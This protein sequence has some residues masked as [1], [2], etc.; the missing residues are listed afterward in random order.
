M[1]RPGSIRRVSW[2]MCLAAA[3][4]GLAASTVARADD[5]TDKVNAPFKAIAEKSRSDLIILP[6]LAAMDPAPAVLRTQER[7][8]LLGSKG[9][10]WQECADW[11]QKPAQ[12]AVLEAIAQVTKE[13]DRL[14]AFA[15][16]QPYGVEGVSIDL[17][18]K[19][20]YTELGDPPLLSDARHLYMPAMENA[21]ILSHVEASRL[22]ASGDLAG[23]MKVMVDWMFFARQIA[24]RPMIKEKKWAMQSMI[25]ASERLRDLVYQDLVGDKPNID[26]A[27]LR[28][29]NDRLKE[30]RGFL[31]LDRIQFPEGDFVA[32]EQLV[33]QVFVTNAGP[34]E[35]TFPGT[36]ARITATDR[37]LT[38]FAG[39][40]FWGSAMKG[41]ANYR[42]TTSMLSGIGDDWR[43]RWQLDP[44]DKYVNTATDYRKRVQTTG[45][46]AVLNR[47]F[48]DVDS[49]FQLRRVLQTEVAGTR[50]AIGVYAFHVRFKSFPVSLAPVRP[51][52]IDTI[53]KDP[54]SSKKFDIRYL[55]PVRDTVKG[56]NGEE[57]LHAINLYP[58]APYPTFKVELGADRFVLY[59]V[60]PDD[61][62]GLAVYATQTRVGVPGDYLLFPPTISL[63]RQRLLETNELK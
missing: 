15:F 48:D 38:R 12:K 7:A 50:L 14:K 40:A 21:G 60:G 3:V 61:A 53:D 28:K 54:Y 4:L 37:P 46:F 24:D 59:S 18:S 1:H 32:R 47:A 17:I 26:A 57:K 36:M 55:V 6:K 13:E 39:A 51:E 35:A 63:Y 49:L 27:A 34:N 33:K 2:T 41:H 42:E 31:A 62:P 22:H 30:R 11:A 25:L 44:F 58:P 29:V 9:P 8:A 16:A 23:A 10:G 52:F 56:A 5:F 45:K 19:N 43:R 20:M